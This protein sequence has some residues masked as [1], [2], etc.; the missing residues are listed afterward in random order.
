MGLVPQL[1]QPCL[2]VN[3]PS[4]SQHSNSIRNV[5]SSSGSRNVSVPPP[6]DPRNISSVSNPAE[7]FTPSSLPNP[8]AA[9]QMF[10][11]KGKSGWIVRN[12][13][14]KWHPRAAAHWKDGNLPLGWQVELLWWAMA[15]Q[16]VCQS[17][18]TLVSVPSICTLSIPVANWSYDQCRKSLCYSGLQW[19][20][21]HEPIIE[22]G[23]FRILGCAA[24]A[25]GSA[26]LCSTSTFHTVRVWLDRRSMLPAGERNNIVASFA[27]PKKTLACIFRG[28]RDLRVS[29]NH[30]CPLLIFLI[31]SAE[32]LVRQ[33]ELPTLRSQIVGNIWM[34]WVES[35][36]RRVPRVWVSWLTTNFPSVTLTLDSSCCSLF[37]ISLICIP[38]VPHKAVAEV[39]RIGNV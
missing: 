3:E 22:P 19:Y 20:C 31:F 13:Q 38:V 18:P 33:Q 23:S 32:W 6:T 30:N 8:N 17:K 10:Q 21:V 12:H 27:D 4:H 35:R 26:R 11:T 7:C 5:E 34:H 15:S 39:S 29:Y 24:I 28:L 9:S 1:P 37:L 16:S 36:V 14:S 25:L 2:Q